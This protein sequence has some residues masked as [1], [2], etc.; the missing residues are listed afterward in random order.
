MKTALKHLRWLLSIRLHIG[1]VLLLLILLIVLFWAT[2]KQSYALSPVDGISMCSGL[3][4]AVAD[5]A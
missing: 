5:S 3:R 1:T 2:V 4:R